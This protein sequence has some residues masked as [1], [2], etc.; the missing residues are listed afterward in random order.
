MD[1]QV[2]CDQGFLFPAFDEETS[3]CK[4]AFVGSLDMGPWRVLS[5]GPV[6]PN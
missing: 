2:V 1:S 5:A 6:E 3:F 4:A